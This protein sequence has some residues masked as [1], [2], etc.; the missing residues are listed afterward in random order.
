[1]SKG[2]IFDIKE[3]SIHDG[4]GTRVTVFMKGCPLRC[5]WCHNPEGIST[6]PQRNGQTGR[7]IGEEWTAQDLALRIQRY[8]DYFESFGGGVTFSGGEPTM[9]AEFLM[10]CVERLPHIHK[11]L[12]TSG[13]C[14]EQIFMGLARQFNAFYYD[15]KIADE[16]LHKQYTGVSNKIILVNLQ[17]LMEM[18]SDVTLRMPMIPGITDTEENL[19][20]TARLIREFC[21]KG[22]P[23]HLLPYN[24]LAEGKYPLYEMEYPL[25]TGHRQNRLAAIAQ[26]QAKMTGEGYQVTNYC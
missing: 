25:H 2:I 20:D 21:P 10:D 14:D 4:P 11:L 6:A 24:S 15:M 12:D 26:F 18:H 7:L 5:Q 23:I 16:N 19:S 22:T 8:G 17:H 3:F 9:Q 13:Y 1:M